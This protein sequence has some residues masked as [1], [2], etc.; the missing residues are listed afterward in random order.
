VTPTGFK[1]E[2]LLSYIE[3]I[4]PIVDEEIKFS[5]SNIKINPRVWKN[6]TQKKEAKSIASFINNMVKN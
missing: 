6:T 3:F 2:D 1:P 5:E 4:Q